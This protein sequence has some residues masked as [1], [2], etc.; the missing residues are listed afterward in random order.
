[1]VA[2]VERFVAEPSAVD[3]QTASPLSQ[4]H[5]EIQRAHPSTAIEWKWVP[6][7]EFFN[8]FPPHKV[9]LNLREL[10]VDVLSFW[11][12]VTFVD[13]DVFITREGVP[14]QTVRS[15]V[16][17]RQLSPYPLIGVQ[18]DIPVGFVEKQVRDLFPWPD[19]EKD[20]FETGHYYGRHGQAPMNDHDQF[21]A[22]RCRYQDNH[23]VLPLYM[24]EK[25]QSGMVVL[26]WSGKWW[27]PNSLWSGYRNENEQYRVSRGCGEVQEWT[28]INVRMYPPAISHYNPYIW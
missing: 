21:W 4:K 18:R 27:C 22:R 8:E 12:P 9:T 13:E 11:E 26:R 3:P 19:F 24:E 1:M 23:E 5:Q 28:G 6:G 14:I 7:R 16:P 17:L 2:V 25:A 10:G 20:L 15:P